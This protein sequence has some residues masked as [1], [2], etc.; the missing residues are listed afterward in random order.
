VTEQSRDVVVSA[1]ATGVVRRVLVDEG[2]SVEKDAAIIEITVQ[3]PTSPQ[4]ANTNGD[5]AKADRV[6]AAN[7]ASAEGEAKRAAAELQRIEP[8][9]KRGLASKAE[10]DKARAQSIDAQQ[11][12]TVA[13][14]G[15][16]KAVNRNQPPAIASSEQVVTVRVPSAGTLRAFTI[17]AGDQVVAGQP[18]A[19]LASRT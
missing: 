12:L 1:P 6:A 5:E 18:I 2:A 15:A 13:R 3:P 14:E 8:L 10:L 19:T 9:V 17:H 11:R 16:H 7:L 4:P